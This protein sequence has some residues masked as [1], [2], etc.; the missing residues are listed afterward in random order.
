MEAASQVPAAGEHS[1]ALG[2]DLHAHIGIINI[3]S[4]LTIR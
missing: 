4:F 2:D 1:D 3:A